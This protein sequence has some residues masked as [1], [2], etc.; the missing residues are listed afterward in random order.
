MAHKLL[1]IVIF[2]KQKESVRGSERV[3]RQVKDAIKLQNNLQ[4]EGLIAG[5]DHSSSTRY[6]G[7]FSQ[8]DC[9]LP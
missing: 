2:I 3:Q 9:P 8:F 4:H 6:T 1:N 7:I 5:V